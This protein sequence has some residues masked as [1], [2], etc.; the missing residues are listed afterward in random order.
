MEVCAF[1]IPFYLYIMNWEWVIA[2]CNKSWNESTLE[3]MHLH[4]EGN[5]SMNQTHVLLNL[6]KCSR[7]KC[8]GFI[9]LDLPSPLCLYCMYG[10]IIQRALQS[11]NSVQLSGCILHQQPPV[12]LHKHNSIHSSENTLFPL[13]N[14]HDTFCTAS[15]SWPRC[16]VLI[17]TPPLSLSVVWTWRF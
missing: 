10:C 12:V 16:D 9:E 11:L 7:I 5:L 4:E 1:P 8:L 2:E 17:A 6:L 15:R 14:L 3:P 13:D